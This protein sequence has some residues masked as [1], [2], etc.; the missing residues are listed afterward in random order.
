M[1][2][3]I[4]FFPWVYIDEPKTFGRL[5]LIPYCKGSLPGDLPNV[6]Q[7]DIDGTLGAYANRP[8][9]HVERSTLL[10]FGEW[11]AG[12]DTD[13]TQIAQLFRARNLIAFSALSH[14]TLFQQHLGYCNYDTYSLV[15]QRYQPGD[16]AY[17]A[18]DSRRRDGRTS[19]LWGSDEFAFFRPNHVDENSRMSLDEP[20]LTALLDLPEKHPVYEACV[21]Y[22]SA[23]T[24]SRDVPEHVELVMCK[25]A[26][27]WLFSI[28]SNVKSLVN[29]LTNVLE[30]IDAAPASG[31]LIK[32]WKARYPD[33]S[34]PLLA[35]VRDFCAV[36]GTS[37]HGQSRETSPFIWKA[38]QHLAFI[39]LL[40]PLL[41]KKVLADE[42]R[43]QLDAFDLER[44]KRI[45]AFLASDPFVHNWRDQV[46]IHPWAKASRD[47]LVASRAHLLY[48]EGD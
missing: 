38:H 16:T 15:V 1:P 7:M 47:S 23:N 21:E 34:R 5:R 36:R 39:A 33:A 29:A 44:L 14:R 28:N 48:P 45:D 46:A 18:F 6:V 12:M 3:T 4:A 42:G 37:A 40:F 19:H 24:D 27:E 43:M 8:N 25:S 2:N 17:F 26:L 13:Q 41:V 35:W 9:R 31:S 11:Q 20:L 10:E 32:Q 30:G 22:C